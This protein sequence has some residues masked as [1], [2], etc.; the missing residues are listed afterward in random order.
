[1]DQC[2][3]DENLQVLVTC[4]SDGGPFFLIIYVCLSTYMDI[5]KQN[6]Y[7]FLLYSEF[8]A[9]TAAPWYSYPTGSMWQ[10]FRTSHFFLPSE[11]LLR[12]TV[13]TSPVW[14]DVHFSQT[15]L[16]LRPR[17]CWLIIHEHS[18][19][20][21]VS[22]PTICFSDLHYNSAE[23]LGPCSSGMCQ[24]W[25]EVWPQGAGGQLFRGGPAEIIHFVSETVNFCGTP[26]VFR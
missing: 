22:I 26:V 19:D 15:F 11:K 4:Q 25:S 18:G 2:W 17:L 20:C 7:L 8:H 12:R 10:L 23:N 14:W 3:P 9:I 6:S 5:E 1:M 24:W 21:L 13:N 16:S